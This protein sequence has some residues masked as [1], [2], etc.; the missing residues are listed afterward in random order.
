M[1]KLLN[2]L[3]FLSICTAK[4]SFALVLPENHS[5]NG[6]LTII[7]ID[8]SQKPE[9]YFE[10]KRIPV[11]ASTKP[12]QWLLIV[13]IPLKDTD[14]IQYINITKPIKTSIPF[15]ISEKFYT[16]QFLNIKDISKVDPQPQ[17]LARIEKESQ[18][19]T[20]IFANYSDSN[21]FE[22]QYTAPLRGPIT[23]LFG[24][25]RVYNKQPR[26][27]HSGLDIAAEQGNR[28]ML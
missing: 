15:H 9:A 22:Q 7:P 20:Q 19:L 23:S 28:S 8:I 14:C 12:K 1:K 26:D 13:A 6:G 11:L 16:T 5:V 18:K 24:L 27:P 10:G 25:K 21:P 4:F 17:D 2:F 3:V